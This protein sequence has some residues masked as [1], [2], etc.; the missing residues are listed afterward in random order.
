[1]LHN[2]YTMSTHGLSDMSRESLRINTMYSQ[3]L[4][5]SMMHRMMLLNHITTSGSYSYSSKPKIDISR[6]LTL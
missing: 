4:D 5:I 3:T 2:S 6:S 1:M